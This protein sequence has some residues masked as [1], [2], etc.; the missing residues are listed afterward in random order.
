MLELS[1]GIS[2][3]QEAG[4]PGVTHATMIIADME[5]LLRIHGNQ[6]HQ[7]LHRL[8]HSLRM[9]LETAEKSLPPGLHL[10]GGAT[11]DQLIRHLPPTVRQCLEQRVA[12]P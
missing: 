7:S 4:Q 8:L 1:P 12:L 2:S 6:R 10:K 5:M 11:P 3:S 9:N